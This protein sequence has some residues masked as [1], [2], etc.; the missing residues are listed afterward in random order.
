M[1][2]NLDK[3]FK[4]NPDLEKNGVWF[5]IS[6]EIAFLVRP[7]KSTNPRFKAAM[8]NH[9]KPF[10]RQMDMGTLEQDKAFEVSLKLFLDV[11]LVDWRGVEIDD[12]PTEYNKENALKFFKALPELFDTLWNYA[13][14]FSSYKEELG[15]S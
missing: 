9:Y 14:D 10:A 1:K 13:K 3:F 11:C 8:A 7:F 6:D 4:T 12:K 15:N 2:T 5:E